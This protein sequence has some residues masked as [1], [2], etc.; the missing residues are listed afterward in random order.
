MHVHKQLSDLALGCNF[1]SVISL[2]FLVI[3]NISQDLID[4]KST[5]VQVMDGLVSSGKKPLN[6]HEPMLTKI[7]DAT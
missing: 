4:N 5:L 3:L 1:E 6:E 7:F 2:L